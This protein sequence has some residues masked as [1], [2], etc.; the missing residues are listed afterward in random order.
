MRSRA[1]CA[2]SS[3]VLRS[4]MSLQEPTISLGAP[5]APADQPLLVIDPATGAVLAAEPVLDGVAALPKQ[6]GR[7]RLHGREIVRMNAIPPEIG[8][9]EILAGLVAE[10][11]LILALTKVG[12]KSPVASKL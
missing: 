5:S 3:A 8:A 1:A 10:E 4:V 12:A 7:L 6:L 2:A 11:S 9:F